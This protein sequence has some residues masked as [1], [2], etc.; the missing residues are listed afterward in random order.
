ML[1]VEI[2]ADAVSVSRITRV[3]ALNYV[4]ITLYFWLQN[5]R[6]FP[7][8][9]TIKLMSMVKHSRWIAGRSALAK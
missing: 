2:K 7:V 9:S 5:H 6:E 8:W 1:H 4:V 3:G